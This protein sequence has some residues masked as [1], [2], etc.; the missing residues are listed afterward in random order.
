MPQI[1]T[2]IMKWI[3]AILIT[4]SL[5]NEPTTTPSIADEVFMDSNYYMDLELSV[6]EAFGDT[7]HINPKK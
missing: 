2:I 7:I 1:K 6:L 5:Y 4:L 3:I